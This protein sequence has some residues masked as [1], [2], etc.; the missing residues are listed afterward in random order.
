ML[1]PR[2]AVRWPLCWR[3]RI[4]WP[5]KTR[6]NIIM[7]FAI[8]ADTI[9][10]RTAANSTKP[11]PRKAA[12]N[13]RLTRVKSLSRKILQHQWGWIGK[14]LHKIDRRHQMQSTQGAGG[15]GNH[16]RCRICGCLQRCS[17][18]TGRVRYQTLVRS[19]NMSIWLYCYYLTWCS[20]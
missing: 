19:R 20:P 13:G 18:C 8:A 3:R 14:I 2:E 12:C 9:L 1:P 4:Q 7:A 6:I 16:N 17:I 11:P 15:N 10:L 5:T